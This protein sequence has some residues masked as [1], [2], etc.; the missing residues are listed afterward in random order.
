MIRVEKSRLLSW[1]M[2]TG[3]AMIILIS[4]VTFG[5][6]SKSNYHSISIKSNESIDSV[7]VTMVDFELPLPP[8]WDT[9]WVQPFYMTRTWFIPGK[10]GKI[11][12]QFTVNELDSINVIIYRKLR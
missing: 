6:C 2:I 5:S 7:M 8:K 9:L 10:N 11:K 3:I 4:M 1:S 12:Y